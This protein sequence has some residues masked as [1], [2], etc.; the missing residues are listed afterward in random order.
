MRGEA[1]RRILLGAALGILCGGALAHAQ[2]QMPDPKEM[3][4]IPRPVDDLPGGS[5]SVRLI[6]G[7]LSN[8]IANHPIDLQIGDAVQTVATDDAGRAQFDRVPP[9]SRLKA[10]AIVDGE[11]LESQEFSAPAQGGIRLML[12]ATDKQKEARAAA[13]ASAP[14]VAGQVTFGDQSR[15]VIQ[16]GDEVIELYYI[17][18][19]ANPTRTPINP[20]TPFTFD[21]PSDAAGTT[22]LQG[23]S[24]K[25]TVSGRHV[26]VEGPFPPGETLVQ[27]AC[28]LAVGSDAID[29]EQTFPATLP[30]LSVIVK[31]VENLRLVSAQLEQQQDVV[32]SGEVFISASGGAIPA[33]QPVMLTVSGLPHH[34]S[35]PRLA[36]L[37][38]AVG[39]VL[40]GLWAV[41]RPAE[42]SGGRDDR[43]RLISRRE[44]LFQDLVRLEGDRQGGRG[45]RSRQA[46]RREELLT[47]LE[48]IYAALDTDGTEP[49]PAGSPGP[50]R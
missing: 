16:P 26:L 1:V 49:Q 27:V 43:K 10:V 20:P 25:V 23:S 48:Q 8:N 15:I 30:R 42:P 14:A 13:E 5:I 45:D 12:V 19:I 7:D 22:V 24:P 33:G 4:G 44:K 38:A 50:A 34:S 47:A 31:K 3:A 21:M 39:V 11:R 40:V 46:S 9:G 32:D 37:S 18:A 35:A 2:F 6:R 28:T 17:L 29:I 41:L 36:A